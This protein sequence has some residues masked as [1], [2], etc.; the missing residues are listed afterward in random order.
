MQSDPP[1]TSGKL[2]D[3]AHIGTVVGHSSPLVVVVLVGC[4]AAGLIANGANRLNTSTPQE[5]Y[6]AQVAPSSADGEG[7]VTRLSQ[8]PSHTASD[9][10]GNCRTLV[11]CN[12]IEPLTDNTRECERTRLA[13]LKIRPVSV[14]V[15]LGAR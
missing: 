1:Q 5:A 6:S 8:V 15:R 3:G 7:G 10:G 2:R 12:E 9:T 4:Y 11:R 14:R 13:G